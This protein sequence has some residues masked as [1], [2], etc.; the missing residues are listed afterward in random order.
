VGNK[1][2]AQEKIDE[3]S[4]IMRYFSDRLYKMGDEKVRVVE[5]NKI[6]F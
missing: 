2:I 3:I 1:N 6:I 5:E 4:E